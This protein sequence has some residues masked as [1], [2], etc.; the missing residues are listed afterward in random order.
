[1]VLRIDEEMGSR[2]WGSEGLGRR[3]VWKTESEEDDGDGENALMD[4]D[5][6]DGDGTDSRVLKLSE[7]TGFENHGKWSTGR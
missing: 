6:N 1:M 4:D 5:L 3:G 2:I 7:E